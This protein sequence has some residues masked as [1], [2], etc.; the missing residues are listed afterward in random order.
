MSYSISFEN[1]RDYL[2]AIVTGENSKENV[3]AYLAELRR[4]CERRDCFRVLIEERLEGPRLETM[5]VFDIAA[6]GCKRVLGFYDVVAYVDVY[7]GELLDFVESVAV[8]RGLP[9]AAFASVEDAE[10][11]L[12][13]RPGDEVAQDIFCGGADR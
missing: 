1:K 10:L 3:T 13:Q 7:A 11:W 8:D 5:D 2:H 4:E 12:R 9:I 6:K